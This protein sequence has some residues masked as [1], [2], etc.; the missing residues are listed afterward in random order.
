MLH[1]L[2]TGAHSSGLPGF[3]L[4]PLSPSQSLGLP[5]ALF[6]PCIPSK[7]PW[8]SGISLHPSGHSTFLKS[9][10]APVQTSSRLLCATGIYFMHSLH[11]TWTRQG[12]G[13]CRKMRDQLFPSSRLV[14][15]EL[16]T[17]HTEA[18]RVIRFFCFL[19]I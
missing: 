3:P 7:S 18:E 2:L 17:S 12:I 4:P 19:S 16:Q 1:I 14:L 6:P 11:C 13:D 15:H 5:I 8:H 10:T 9:S